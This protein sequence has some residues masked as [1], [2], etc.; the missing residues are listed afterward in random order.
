MTACYLTLGAGAGGAG[1]ATGLAAGGGADL[2]N[3]CG[4]GGGGA[5]LG[6]TEK[7]EDGREATVK[8]VPAE[9]LAA[10]LGGGGGA[11]LGAGLGAAGLSTSEIAL[12]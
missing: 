7:P 8:A 11:G 4:G 5:P 10:G 12:S 2:T 6:A 1:L 3:A 9:G